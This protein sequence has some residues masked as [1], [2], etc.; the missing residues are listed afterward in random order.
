MV[1]CNRAVT[2]TSAPVSGQQLIGPQLDIVNPLLWEIGH[3]AYFYELWTLRHLDNADSFLAN[4]DAL[5]DSI[6]IAHNDR[7]DLPLL[8]LAETKAYMKQVHDAV[9]KRLYRSDVTAQDIYLTRYAVFHEDMHTEAFTYTRRTLDYP[10]PDFANAVADDEQFHAGALEGDVEIPGGRFMLGADKNSDF[11]FDNEKWQHPVDI[12]PFAIARAATT[13]SQYAEFVDAGGY[14]DKQYW[15]EEGW[16]WLQESKMTAPG[17]WQKDA[18]GNW[19]IRH[20]DQWEPLRPHAAVIH[21]SWYEACAW[22]RWANR[23]LPT[24]AEWECAAAGIPGSDRKN[25]YPWGE[26][27]PSEKTANLDGRALRTID[28]G[29]LPDSDSAYGCRQML[30]NVWEWTADTFN[31]YPGFTPDMYQ[32]YSRPLFGSTRVLRGGAWTTRSRMI[33]NTWRNYYGAGRN[34]VFAGFRSCAL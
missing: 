31:P 19:L 1:P 8:S 14:L 21:I 32:D 29:A 20:F 18:Q 28:V 33:R 9:I 22:C 2:V 5:Y 23:R 16:R 7:W 3:V 15:D 13:Y 6:N 4:A 17:G 11:C 10:V 27:A 30:G 34:D 12:K 26:E 24:E 25:R